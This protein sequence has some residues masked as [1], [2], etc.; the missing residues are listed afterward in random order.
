MK[1]VLFLTNYASPYRV[2]FF[3][4]LRKYCHV[5]V[6]FSE[7][8]EEKKHRDA[9]W[10]VESH[11]DV[12]YVQLEKR[13]ASLRGKD[14]CTDV[15]DWLQKPFDKI[16]ICGY[17][18]PTNML[19]MAYL[20]AKKIPFCMEIDGGLIRPD[21]KAMY[22]FKRALV[23][24]ADS[25]LSTGRESD[26]YLIHYGAAP[27][28]IAHYPFTSL[29]EKDILTALPSVEEKQQLRQQLGMTEEKIVL[30]V[31]RID[32]GKGF[33]V[34][35]S[36]ADRL[37]EN[38]GLYIV[39]GE[40]TE[41]LSAMMQEKNLH[42]V[43]FLGFRKK[44]DLKAYYQAADLF[45][46]PTR[47]DVWGLVINEAMANGLPVVTTDRCVAG[48]ELVTDGVNGYI[49]PV[50]DAQALAE[51][52]N[53]VLADDYAAMGTASLNAIRPFTI[54]NMAKVHADFFSQE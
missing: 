23:R 8:I 46:L 45:V 41:D 21:S 34:L 12:H 32:K 42:N 50:D 11:S 6:L 36:G 33:D 26:R 37:A 10:F 49:V 51:K 14:L 40:P 28:G 44:E 52:I 5:T 17:S 7:R 54:E 25:W 38:T 15:I 4:E 20:K 1:Q 35:L 18:S 2:W 30:S 39:G 24:C 48:V 31:A 29:W 3:D 13:K 27:K 43:H 53:A 22:L 9:A 16:V 47:S 19:A